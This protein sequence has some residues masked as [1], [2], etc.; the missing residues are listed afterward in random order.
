M[1]LRTAVLA[2]LVLFVLAFGWTALIQAQSQK[3]YTFSWYHD[4]VGTDSYN[5]IV[6]A[7]TPLVVPMT[8][9]SGT[10]ATRLCSASVVLTTNVSHAVVIEAVNIFGVNDSDPFPAGP[11]KGKPVGVTA[12]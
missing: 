3:T 6:D 9:C 2:T 8:A 1:R 12:K 5:V 7:G 4:G 11:P 10:G